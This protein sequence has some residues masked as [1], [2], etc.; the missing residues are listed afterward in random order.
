MKLDITR[1]PEPKFKIGRYVL[2]ELELVKLMLDVLQGDK[3]EGIK[4]KCMMSGK[5]AVI[6]ADG[7]LDKDLPGFGWKA[8]LSRQIIRHSK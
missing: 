6:G 3:P 8:V 7:R 2:T 4:V 5:T 1:I